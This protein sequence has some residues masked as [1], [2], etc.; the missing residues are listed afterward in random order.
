MSQMVIEYWFD[1]S[2][3]LSMVS[4]VR[5]MTIA[6]H[7][8]AECAFSPSA[9]CIWTSKLCEVCNISACYSVYL[10]Y[11]HV[12]L[13]ISDSKVWEDLRMNGFCGNISGEPFS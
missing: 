8:Q 4:S 12:T 13:C 11:Q 9:F 7:L 1:V 2:S 6:R 3:L 5:E 10:T